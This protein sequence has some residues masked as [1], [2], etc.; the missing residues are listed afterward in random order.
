MHML[1]AMEAY[2]ALGKYNENI[3]NMYDYG[4]FLLRVQ[5]HGKKIMLEPSLIG[6]LCSPAWRTI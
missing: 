4:D 1:V 2:K 5:A 6:H 3:V